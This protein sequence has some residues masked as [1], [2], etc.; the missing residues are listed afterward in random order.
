M[1]SMPV[2]LCQSS[3]SSMNRPEFWRNEHVSGASALPVEQHSRIPECGF[4]ASTG[5]G[6]Y[7][8]T[9]YDFF[10][11]VRCGFLCAERIWLF[12]L[13]ECGFF[14]L[15]GCGFSRLSDVAFH[16][17]RMWLF[18]LVECG[19][20]EMMQLFEMMHGNG[21]EMETVFESEARGELSSRRVKLTE[22]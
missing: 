1:M 7:A 4:Y 6:F 20:F 5:Y 17:C 13:V 22:S 21:N 3:G 10:M 16:A 2:R 8:S 12:M 11:P 9:G 18:M 15:A 19:F 14:M